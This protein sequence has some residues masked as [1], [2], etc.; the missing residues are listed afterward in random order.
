MWAIRIEERALTALELERMRAGFDENT[1]ANGVEIQKSERIDCIALADG[2]YVGCIS[3]LAYRNGRGYSSWFNL[4]D[5]IVEQGYRGKGIGSRL[6]RTI[7][8]KLLGLGVDK[9][10]VWT[11]GY[12]APRFYQA[13]GYTIAT[14]LEGWYSNGERRIGLRKALGPRRA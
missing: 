3:G 6:L 2:Q 13:R 9:I 12:E 11:A 14:E 10:W 8:D 1:V 5:L 7:E 4:T